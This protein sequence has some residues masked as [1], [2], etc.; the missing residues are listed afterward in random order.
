MSES[1]KCSNDRDAPE[2]HENWHKG[3]GLGQIG[4]NLN[5]KINDNNELEPADSMG[6]RDCTLVSIKY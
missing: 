1:K 6:I 4:D 2:G 3:T 5:M